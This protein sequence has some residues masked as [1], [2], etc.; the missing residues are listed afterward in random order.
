[1]AIKT[2]LGSRFVRRSTGCVIH[3]HSLDSV[4]TSLNHSNGLNF[5]R[6][7]EEF[8]FAIVLCTYIYT[9]RESGCSLLYRSTDIGQS[10][11]S[12]ICSS[13]GQT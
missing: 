11:V 13:M 12:S 2:L 9:E 1:M 7:S 10:R 3:Y 5:L 8:L 4:S 6:T